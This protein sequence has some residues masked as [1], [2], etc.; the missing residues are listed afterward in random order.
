MVEFADRHELSFTQL[1]LMYVLANASEPLAITR[2]AELT[3]GSLP[4]TARAV[5]VLV[6]QGLADRTEDS[7][8]RRVKLVQITKLGE[9]S[10]RGIFDSRIAVLREMLSRLSSEEAAALSGAL[11]PLIATLADT[12]DDDLGDTQ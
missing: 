12:A 3:D 6:R 2:I 11:A 7:A 10:M 4:T 9:T 1:K 8:D 5:D